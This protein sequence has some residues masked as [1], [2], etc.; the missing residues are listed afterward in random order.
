[1]ELQGEK[2]SDL[3]ANDIDDSVKLSDIFDE[4]LRIFHE[5]SKTNEPTNSPDVQVSNEPNYQCL[6]HSVT[7][8][9]LLVIMEV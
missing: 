6:K 4:G 7:L 9:S 2:S 5:V 3:A 1:M 8:G